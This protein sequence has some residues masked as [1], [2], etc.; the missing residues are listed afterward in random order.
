MIAKAFTNA[1]AVV[2]TLTTAAL[3][4]EYVAAQAPPAR[5]EAPAL[6][7][8]LNGPVD[9][10]G[11]QA[12]PAEALPVPD[13][14]QAEA[15]E[16]LDQGPLHE[17]FAEAVVLEQGD[18]ITIQR[19]PPE[20]INELVPEVRPEGKNVEWIPGY[21]MWSD[22]RNDFI[23][24]SG[25]WRD[26]P[27]GRRWVPGHWT[28]VDNGA[29]QWV[30]GFWAG[31]QVQEVN[32]LPAPPETLEAGP[33]SPAPAAN[34]FWIPGSWIW[35]NDAYSWRAGYWYAGQQNWVWIPDRYCYTPRGVIFVSGYWDYLLPYRGLAYAPVW[36]SRPVWG[37]PGW[38]YRPYNVLN[39]N[40]LLTALF[41]NRHH[42]HYYFG[43]GNWNHRDHYNA[44]WR[45]G[46]GRGYDP[47]Y[48]YH[49][50]HDGGNRNNDWADRYRRDFDRYRQDFDRPGGGGHRN[51]LIT[52][53]DLQRHREIGN[54]R[55]TQTSQIDLDR[56][57]QKIDQFRS[58][59][60][61]RLQADARLQEFGGAGRK[62]S[63]D[64]L[65]NGNLGADAANVPRNRD[66]RG[67][68]RP[69]V[70]VDGR[71][72]AADGERNRDRGRNVDSDSL[73][74]AGRTGFRLPPVERTT[75]KVPLDGAAG[76]AGTRL[77]QAGPSDGRQSPGNRMLSNGA[78]RGGEANGISADDFRRQLR[79]RG[80]NN[81][82]AGA[83]NGGNANA[84]AGSGTIRQGRPDGN[85]AVDG[86]DII[87]G[88]RQLSPGGA[89]DADRV[90]SRGQAVGGDELRRQSSQA[91]RQVP[92]TN[93]PSLQGRPRID[94]SSS[95][96]QAPNAA[97]ARQLEQFR[98]RSVPSPSTSRPSSGAGRI[99]FGPGN[100]GQPAF[101]GGGNEGRSFRSAP[102]IGG[103]QPAVRSQGGGSESRSFRGFSG[104]GGGGSNQSMRSNRDS[105][106][107]PPSRGGGG[108]G[109]RNNGGGRG[110]GR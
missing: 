109:G 54:V 60:D 97:P 17:A 67:P 105:G 44:W 104:G 28:A 58:I 77:P 53:A 93:S 96:V 57:R 29:F 84:G 14:Q 39:S 75:A 22:D 71:N 59:R 21:W 50:W 88:G 56:S 46:G 69:D 81:P 23:W 94:S 102:S 55:L 100:S 99:E 83:I 51:R 63:L 45:T 4:T 108:G 85:R 7:Q 42:H 27:P 95:R 87:R 106:G 2:V 38:A 107:G 49:R 37:T 12:A 62:L 47:F 30:S 72:L 18:T 89:S 15:M 8:P 92:Q 16:V 90:R 19:E 91:P 110:R 43:H 32:M 61:A 76:A 73:R 101:R 31:E 98:S 64:D 68:Q 10:A 74:N 3:V 9:P 6:A 40:L 78:F 52:Q 20:P 48:A 70:A 25:V 103:G 35:N 1:F 82:G 33:S 41:F 86:P 66:G 34:Y 26:I 65:R 36:W 13:G 79:E 5:P 11:A 24:V 80:V